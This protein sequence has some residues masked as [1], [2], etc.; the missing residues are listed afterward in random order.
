MKGILLIFWDTHDKD[1]HHIGKGLSEEVCVMFYMSVVTAKKVDCILNLL[2]MHAH[3][4]T[5][6]QHMTE[7]ISIIN[8]EQ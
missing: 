7:L 3:S 5:A 1:A 6:S 2:V 4:L 8:Q